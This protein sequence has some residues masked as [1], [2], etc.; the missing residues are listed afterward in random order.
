[1]QYRVSDRGCCVGRDVPAVVREIRRDDHLSKCRQ[2]PV[3]TAEGELSPEK[4]EILRGI[5]AILQA[6][7]YTGGGEALQEVPHPRGSNEARED[8]PRYRLSAIFNVVGPGA[9]G[10]HQIRYGE[11]I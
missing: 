6:G 7:P 2:P 8:D 3:A 9:A 11:D 10:E 1:M 4:Q 5:S